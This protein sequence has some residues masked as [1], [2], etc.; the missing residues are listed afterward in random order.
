[1]IRTKIGLDN[2]STT[3]QMPNMSFTKQVTLFVVCR[4]KELRVRVTK[5]KEASKSN[6]DKS[7]VNLINQ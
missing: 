4:Y 7:E 6:E 1:M 3:E 5:T 2:F